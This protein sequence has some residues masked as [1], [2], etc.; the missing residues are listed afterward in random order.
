MEKT[1][2]ILKSSSDPLLYGFST[3]TCEAQMRGIELAKQLNGFI[4]SNSSICQGKF[5]TPIS[6]KGATLSTL[7]EVINK[8]DILIFWGA[9][10]AES[11]PRLLNKVIFSRGKFRLTG[12]EVKTLIVI[13]PIKTSTFNVMGARD[14]ALN[15]KIYKD[16]ELIRLL[17]EKCCT[18]EAIPSEGIAGIDKNDL[19]RLL[20]NI[21]ES[22]NTIIFSGQGL[23]DSPSNTDLLEELLELIEE[24][25]Q[26]QA[27]GRTSLIMMSGHYNMVGFEHV[28]LSTT[29]HY[30]SAQFKEGK[31]EDTTDNIVTKL[32]KGEGDCSIIVGSDPISHLPGSLSNK[33]MAHPIILLDSKKSSTSY[34]AD[35]ILPT[36]LTGIEA[37]GLAYRLDH[38]PIELHKIIDPPKNILSDEEVLSKII[39]KLKSE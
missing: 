4:D 33:M 2:E 31:I 37:S 12:R 38:V 27:K 7:S 21:T 9:N 24:V 16:I 8:A 11:I 30:G 22:E 32:Q 18:N 13:D 26:K 23:L 36:A 14:L 19:K 25:N 39:A 1:V 20:L 35:V 6:K 28:L 34:M 10:P 17:K 15:I 29:G 3:T 5:L